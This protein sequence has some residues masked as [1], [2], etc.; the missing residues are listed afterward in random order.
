MAAETTDRVTIW[1]NWKTN[2]K[3]DIRF[4]SENDD[5]MRVKDMVGQKGLVVLHTV[6]T[7]KGVDDASI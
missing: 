1:R 2:A 6:I 5:G 7:K 3:T 4:S